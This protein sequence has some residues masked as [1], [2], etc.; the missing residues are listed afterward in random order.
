MHRHLAPYDTNIKNHDPEY[1][2]IFKIGE[3]GGS[4]GPPDPDLLHVNQKS[5]FQIFGGRLTVA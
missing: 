5:K 1:L 3:G 2:E 4:R